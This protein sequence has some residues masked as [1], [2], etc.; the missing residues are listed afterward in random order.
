[1]DI[2]DV[3][4][5]CP[6][7]QDLVKRLESDRPVTVAEFKN[8]QRQ[9]VMEDGMVMRCVKLPVDGEVS[10]PVVPS[11]LRDRVVAIAHETSGIG[12]LG[13]IIP[14]AK[15]QMLFPWYRECAPRF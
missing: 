15:G 14:N 7:I 6:I 1:M 9:L 11:S 5:T 4:M 10:V 2:Q 12:F 13:N 8:V 3:Q